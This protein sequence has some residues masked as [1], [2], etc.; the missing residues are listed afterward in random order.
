MHSFKDPIYVTRP[1]LPDLDTVQAKLKEIWDCQ[2]LTNCGPQ[3]KLLEEA[4]T[5][6]LKVPYLSLFNNGTTSLM[7]ACQA[8]RLSGDVITTPLRLLQRPMF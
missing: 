6:E 5:K 2:W 4:L 3:H 8:L 1:I 7:I